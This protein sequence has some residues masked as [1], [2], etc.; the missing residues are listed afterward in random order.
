MVLNVDPLLL[1]L[2][3]GHFFKDDHFILL[4]QKILDLNDKG[5]ILPVFETR[6]SVE[7]LDLLD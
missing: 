3:G 2:L 4:R 5:I 6:L 7:R 1:I